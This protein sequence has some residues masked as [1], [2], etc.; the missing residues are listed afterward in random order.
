MPLNFGSITPHPPILIPTIGKENLEKLKSTRASLKILNQKLIENE[1]ET[2]I[3]ISPHG[4]I[5]EDHFIINSASN[6]E[7]SFE[8]FGDF[9]VKISVN[10]DLELVNHIKEGMINSPIQ[11][12]EEKK[13]DHGCGVPLFYLIK[14]LPNLK[15]LPIYFTQ[16]SLEDHFNFGKNLNKILKNNKKKIA[17]ISSGDLSHRLTKNAP[18]GYSPKGKKFDNKLIE[19]INNKK[20]QEILNLNENLINDAG[21]CGLRSII[22]LLGALEELKYEPQILS[23]EGPFGVGYLVASFEIKK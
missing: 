3:I 8:E 4:I 2:L 21:E 9:S 17:I 10:G 12:I 1:I 11:I 13:L 18:A 20:T 6:F 14:N 19:L 5:S 15:I 23:Y 22:I 16:L 7:A